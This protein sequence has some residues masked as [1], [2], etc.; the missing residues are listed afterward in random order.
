MKR[1]GNL[2]KDIIDED[3]LFLAAKK[4]A[5][6]KRFQDN[7]LKFNAKLGDNIVK[8]KR[9]TGKYRPGS[10]R[11]FEIFESKKRMISVVHHALWLKP[12]LCLSHKDDR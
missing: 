6:G 11:T 3:N 2:W 10:Y 9:E 8:I 7:V 1:H 12:K 4:A 5:R